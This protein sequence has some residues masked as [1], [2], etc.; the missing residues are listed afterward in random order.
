[1]TF[2]F[3]STSHPDASYQVSS[4]SVQVKRKTDFQDGDKGNHLGFLTEPILAIFDLLVTLM[5]LTKF[6]V[7]WPFG[8]G[9]QAKTRFSRWLPWQPSRISDQNNFK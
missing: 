2:V 1:M 7:G 9:K 6:Q 5:L 3:L 4:L 8:S